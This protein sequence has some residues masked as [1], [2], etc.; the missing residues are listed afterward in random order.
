MPIKRVAHVELGVEDVEGIVGFHEE[1][2]GLERIDGDGGTVFL[3][4]GADDDFDLALS[5]GRGV[6]HVALEVAD[7][8][9]LDLYR[10]RL[11]AAGVQVEPRDGTE[12][13]QRRGLRFTAPTGHVFELV[14]SAGRRLYSQPALTARPRS[15]GIAPL[16]LDHVTLWGQDVEGLVGFLHDQLDLELSDSFQPGPGVWGAAW[17]RAGDFHHDIAVI[18]GPDPEATLHHVA[19]AMDGIDHIKRGADQ[20]SHAGMP[21]ETGPGRHQLGGNLY[22]YFIAP[23]GHR[24]ELSAEMPRVGA[25]EPPGV[26]ADFPPAFSAWGAVPP[27]SFGKGS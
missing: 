14:L 22:A 17:L 21:I 15:R 10:G 1:V 27:E 2:L 26:W 11:A 24:Y 6:R 20:L 3:G 23:G 4:C 19:W 16:D 13:G 18:G 7:E 8:G 5:P 9:D 12:P 25:A